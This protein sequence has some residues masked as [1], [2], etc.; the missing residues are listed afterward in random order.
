LP[1]RWGGFTHRGF[2]MQRSAEELVDGS[3]PVLPCL[4]EYRF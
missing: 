1:H 3:A 2:T 4:R